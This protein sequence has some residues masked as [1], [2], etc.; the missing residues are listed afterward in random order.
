MAMFAQVNASLRL[1]GMMVTPAEIQVQ[2][3]V[4]EGT[5]TSDEA[6]SI[7]SEVAYCRSVTQMEKESGVNLEALKP[8]EPFSGQASHE[9]VAAALRTAWKL[10]LIPRVDDIEVGTDYY[11]KLKK[12]IEVAM[13]AKEK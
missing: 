2:K 5:L 6:V 1:D 3:M 9:M 13:Q 4:A 10:E 7:F 8:A 11:L 12:V